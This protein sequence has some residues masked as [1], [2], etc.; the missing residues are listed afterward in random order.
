MRVWEK[1]M[2]CRGKGAII[3]ILNNKILKKKIKKK[4]FLKK[5][6]LEY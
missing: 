1:M 6:Y 2:G 4:L 5:E 3:Y